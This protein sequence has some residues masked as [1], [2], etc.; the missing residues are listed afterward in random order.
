MNEGK[1]H[2]ADD[3]TLAYIAKLEAE[4]E[5]FYMDYR[6]KCD[7]ETKRLHVELAAAKQHIRTDNGAVIAALQEEIKTYKQ[8]DAILRN[9]NYQLQEEL[10]RIKAAAQDVVERWHT[11]LWK[12]VPATAGYINALAK[13]IGEKRDD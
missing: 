1:T 10:A 6:M 12:D 8:S 11:P 2:H 4:K 13:A 3:D 5:S 7:E 9:E